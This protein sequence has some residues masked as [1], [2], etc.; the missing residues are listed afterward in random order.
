MLG[1]FL[2]INLPTPEPEGRTPTSRQAHEMKDERPQTRDRTDRA[3]T[4]HRTKAPTSDAKEE[5]VIVIDEQNGHIYALA[6]AAASAFAFQAMFSAIF[7][8]Y[9]VMFP[10]MYLYAVQTCPS[11]RSFDAKR[12]LKRV[13]RG[14]HLAEDDPNKPRGFFQRAMA[15]T[16]ATVATELST[17]MGYEITMYNMLGACTLAAVRVPAADTDCFWIGAFGKW[18]YIGQRQ[19]PDDGKM[20]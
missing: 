9:V 18:R 17:G 7:A 8:V 13:L 3:G 6:I 16:R 19:I 10:V 15:K 4:H 11:N 5:P 20:D 14:D 1:G 12:E 2:E